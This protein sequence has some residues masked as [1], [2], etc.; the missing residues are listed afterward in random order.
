MA[1][2]LGIGQL[3][4]AP[5]L[6]A[7]GDVLKAGAQRPEVPARRG[8]NADLAD[9][10]QRETAKAQLH[11]HLVAGIGRGVA[12][13]KREE[14]HAEVRQRVLWHLHVG[15]Q[16]LITR[17]QHT[18]AAEAAR[19]GGGVS[20]EYGELVLAAGGQSASQ[21]E[22]D[23]VVVVQ[24]RDVEGLAAAWG[25][26]QQHQRR[27][28][29]HLEALRRVQL[30]A[31]AQRHGLPGLEPQ[32]DVDWPWLLAAGP[33]RCLQALQQLIAITTATLPHLLKRPLE[34]RLQ[35]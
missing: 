1:A 30:Q 20:G 11:A 26:R 32:E 13:L 28:T 15:F 34:D 18:P 17:Q 12:R 8:F 25:H 16:N 4:G 6:A 35:R 19:N 7:T 33:H 21:A 3:V 29:G 24:P 5:R 22:V 10:A 23:D 14:L 31:P 9:A 27:L 2:L